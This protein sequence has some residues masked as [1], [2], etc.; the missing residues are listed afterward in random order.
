MRQIV[1]TVT[2]ENGQTTCDPVRVDV[3]PGDIV[4]WTCPDGELAIDFKD[5]PFTS[6]QVWR[7]SSDQMTPAAIVKPMP[8]SGTIF[9]PTVSINGTVVAKSL[10]DLIVR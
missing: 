8:S 4:R 1:V 3:A 10:G 5:T 6:T 9:R 7:A 2:S